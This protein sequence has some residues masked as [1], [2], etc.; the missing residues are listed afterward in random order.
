MH[1]HAARAY[2]NLVSTTLRDRLVDSTRR[3]IAAGLDYCEVHDVQ[4]SLA[5]IGA[6]SAHFALNVGQWD[7]AA[8][9]AAE[10]I[11][12]GTIAT[13]QRIPALFVLAAVR[14]RRGDPGVDTLLDE[15]AQ[16]ALPTGELQRIGRIAATRAEVAWYRGD[17]Q[18]VASEARIGLQAAADHR[19]PWMRGELVYWA[20]VAG[21]TVEEDCADLAE[22]YAMMIKGDWEGAAAAWRELEAPYERALALADG[23]EAALLESLTILERW[24]AGPLA[25]IVRQRLRERGVRGIPRGP[26][27]STRGNPAGLTAR[28]V[29]VLRLLVRGHTNNELAL[30]L[31]ISAKTIDHHVSSILEKLEVRS[32]TEAVGAAMGLGILKADA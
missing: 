9:E 4:D 23:P 11:D 22:P 25:A 6:L 2:A 29:Q 21:P 3:Y 8:R 7:K 5:Y 31:H 20:H 19:D 16:L 15:A 24:G 12:S 14:A 30:R 28:E 18:R 26:R 32:R 13:A 27:A 17:M 10:L 1:H